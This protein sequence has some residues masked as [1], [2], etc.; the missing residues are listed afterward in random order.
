MASVVVCIGQKIPKLNNVVYLTPLGENPL[1]SFFP[2]H[3]LP[4]ILKSLELDGWLSR[5]EFNEIAEL[6]SDDKE[7]EYISFEKLEACWGEPFK[8]IRRFFY[9]NKILTSDSMLEDKT[10]SYWI[11]P[12]FATLSIALAVSL[13][14][15]GLAIAWV[16]LFDERQRRYILNLL[17]GRGSEYYLCTLSEHTEFLSAANKLIL[18]VEVINPSSLKLTTLRVNFEKNKS[19]LIEL[20]KNHGVWIPTERIYESL[21]LNGG[22]IPRLPRKINYL[23]LLFGEDSALIHDILDELLNNMPVSLSVFLSILRE[24]FRDARKAAQV[25]RKMLGFKI[26]SVSQ[27]NVYITY[28]GVKLY[29]NYLEASA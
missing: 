28:R 19:G 24:Y 5:R 12:C 1:P 2:G 7:D 15:N 16:D 11:V 25:Y 4:I 22:C 6:I 3:C 13:F 18:D 21:N 8:T 20:V 14:E 26:I 9:G 29:E 27:A 23:K 10:P 17:A